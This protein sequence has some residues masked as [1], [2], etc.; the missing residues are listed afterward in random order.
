MPLEAHWQEVLGKSNQQPFRLLWCL[1]SK[2][3]VNI[4]LSRNKKN[5]ETC[6]APKL[7]FKIVFPMT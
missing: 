5:L 7:T 6:T 4:I 3:M 1:A 2:Q